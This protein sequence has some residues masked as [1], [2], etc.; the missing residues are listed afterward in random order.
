MGKNM[1]NGVE[2]R[3]VEIFMETLFILNILH[4]LNFWEL[5]SCRIFVSTADPQFIA[6]T[7]K[8]LNPT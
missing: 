6:L 7:P 2:T 1:E 8:S 3:C 5:S 4:D